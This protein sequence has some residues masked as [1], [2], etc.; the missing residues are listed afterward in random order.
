M[1]KEFN[2]FNDGNKIRYE[3]DSTPHSLFLESK[4]F[5][6]KRDSVFGANQE[7]EYS[8]DKFKPSIEDPNNKEK[9]TSALLSALEAG[10]SFYDSVNSHAK[11]PYVGQKESA[12]FERA[13]D[14]LKNNKYDAPSLKKAIDR[15][16]IDASDAAKRRRRERIDDEYDKTPSASI[17]QPIGVLFQG[18]EA[19]VRGS[20]G[21]NKFF[22]E[23]MN[24]IALIA[25]KL[26]ELKAE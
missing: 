14:A 6:N 16:I 26:R 19:Y 23:E 18:K 2:A 8:S 13:I 22:G 1:A 5:E 7:P 9:L 20:S 3:G 12:M 15:L 11:D 24:N 17:L 21:I 4:A 25:K 10:K